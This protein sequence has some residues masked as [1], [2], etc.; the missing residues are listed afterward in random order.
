MK[1]WIVMAFCL[2]M[3]LFALS[4]SELLPRGPR[5]YFGFLFYH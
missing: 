2:S 1:K 4:R 5:V 3:A